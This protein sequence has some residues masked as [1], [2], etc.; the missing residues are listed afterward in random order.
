M[1]FQAL[2]NGCQCEVCRNIEMKKRENEGRSSFFISLLAH[3]T[4]WS[5]TDIECSIITESTSVAYL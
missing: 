5:H 2:Y 4:M 3:S 1:N